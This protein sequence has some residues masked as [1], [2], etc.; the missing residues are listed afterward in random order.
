[1]FNRHIPIGNRLLKDV[2]SK[3]IKL[4]PYFLEYLNLRN[5]FVQIYKTKKHLLNLKKLEKKLKHKTFE[6]LICQLEEMTDS[7]NIKFKVRFINELDL[8]YNMIRICAKL[9]E[10]GIVFSNKYLYKTIYK[11]EKKGT[12]EGGNDFEV[13]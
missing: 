5:I 12:N 9:N 3:G 4:R 2:T 13:V 6:E 11:I 1:M 8:V 10:K 7:L